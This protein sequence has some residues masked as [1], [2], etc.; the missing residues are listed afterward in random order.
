MAYIEWPSLQDL[1][2]DGLLTAEEAAAYLRTSPHTLEGWRTR[3]GVRNGPAYVRLGAGPR[4]PV[5]YV[6]QDVR[7][8]LRSRREPGATKGKTPAAA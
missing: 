2:A 8:W 7:E 6:V 5:R 1:P 3:P 4:G